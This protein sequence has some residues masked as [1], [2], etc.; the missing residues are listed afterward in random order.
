MSINTLTNEQRVTKLAASTG[1]TLKRLSDQRVFKLGTSR[2]SEMRGNIT[3]SK[4]PFEKLFNDYV[5]GL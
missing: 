1:S 4:E 5:N 3:D 2:I